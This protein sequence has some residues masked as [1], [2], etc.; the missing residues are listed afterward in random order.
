MH[1]KRLEEVLKK[2]REEKKVANQYCNK[3]QVII[4]KYYFT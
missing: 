3:S 1:W 4:T 2:P